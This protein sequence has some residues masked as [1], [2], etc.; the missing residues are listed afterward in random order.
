ME[1]CNR[2]IEEFPE[3]KKIINKINNFINT[4][5]YQQILDKMKAS[6]KSNDYISPI[7]VFTQSSEY[8]KA[9]EAEK[10]AFALAN[11]PTGR[12]L[13]AYKEK[14]QTD[15]VRI[16][17]TNDLILSF[18]KRNIDEIG[19]SEYKAE[20]LLRGFLNKINAYN[21]QEHHETMRNAYQDYSNA[22]IEKHPKI[23]ETANEVRE[24]INSEG[25]KNARD[26][27][28]IKASKEYAKNQ[29]LLKGRLETAKEELD[30]T[31]PSLSPPP[32]LSKPNEKFAPVIPK[33]SY[34][35]VKHLEI[36]IDSLEK[37]KESIIAKVGK[38]HQEAM[39]TEL[40]KEIESLYENRKNELATE[41]AN[42]AII[43]RI[44]QFV[45]L[46]ENHSKT[47]HEIIKSFGA[48]YND[49]RT[50]ADKKQ[51]ELAKKAKDTLITELKEHIIAKN[52]KKDVSEQKLTSMLHVQNALLNKDH[53]IQLADIEQEAKKLATQEIRKKRSRATGV[54]QHLAGTS[55]ASK[56][57]KIVNDLKE[58]V[59]PYNLTT[60]PRALTTGRGQRTRH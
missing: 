37:K 5:E 28:I 47:K 51:S 22:L 53:Q 36:L 33:G 58:V 13:Y 4:E 42:K 1:Y 52:S 54:M 45:S 49:E 21:R 57:E 19:S 48:K 15:K 17:K 16:K 2:M 8:L 12:L 25:F 31:V 46:E 40:D 34:A 35:V 6:S 11:S 56:V 38:E 29:K 10:K 9:K 32:L 27:D 3:S 43:D 30:K 20:E 18:S 44:D 24:Y 7:T 60:K 14:E 55:S 23:K 39:R 50:A 26:I 41:P 59:H